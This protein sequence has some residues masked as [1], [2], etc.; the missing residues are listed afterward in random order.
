L[1]TQAST[2]IYL[3]EP[4]ALA[5]IPAERP[6]DIGGELFPD[7]VRRGLPFYAQ[8]HDFEWLDIGRVSDYWRIVQRMLCGEVR[9]IEM[10]GQEVRH[11]VWCG[12]N[13]RVA[14]DSVCID[15]PV[16]IGSGC[17]IEPGVVIRGPAWIGDGCRIGMG[18]TVERS[19][20]F[21]YTEVGANAVARE[22]ILSGR[23]C[24]NRD[25]QQSDQ[26]PTGRTHAGWWCDAR[27]SR[28]ARISRAA[29]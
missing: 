20:L 10:P 4:Q 2:G 28:T 17:E 23:Y 3:I 15:G 25:G 18:A 16:Y 29:S 27:S 26:A 8:S 24:V 14:W 21:E 6:Y 1:S 9:G 7:L 12:M 22:M 13:T 19:V 5:L 11:G